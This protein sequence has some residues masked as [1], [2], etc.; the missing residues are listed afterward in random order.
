M[1][2]T[3]FSQFSKVAFVA[4]AM[5]IGGLQAAQAADPVTPEAIARA[6]VMR[7]IGKNMKVLGE[8]ANGKAAF[9]GEAATAAKAALVAAGEALPKAFETQGAADPA[10]EA[11]PEIW[12]NWDDYLVKAAALSDGAAALDVASAESIKA[13]MGGIGGSCKACHSVYRQ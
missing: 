4:G 9:D 10:S 3:K 2:F 6:E 8:M 5:A 7:E 12:T 13:S 1:L 11:K